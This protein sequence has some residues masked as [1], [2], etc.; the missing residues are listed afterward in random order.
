LQSY[1]LLT[2]SNYVSTSRTRRG[3]IPPGTLD[4]LILKTLAR[5]GEKH[6]FEMAGSIQQI[7]DDVQVEEGSFYPALHG[8]S[9][10]AGL[11]PSG[12]RPLEIAG[13]A[14]TASPAR[15][16]SRSI[17]ETREHERVAQAVARIFQPA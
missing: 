2:E 13:L 9:F 1:G 14:I 16:A 3:E 6:G 5:S 7:S 15:G 8:C 10:R 17:A 4:I 12:A 11:Q